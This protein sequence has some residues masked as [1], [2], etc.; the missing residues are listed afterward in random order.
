MR[1]VAPADRRDPASEYTERSELTER[2]EEAGPV[3]RRDVERCTE[4]GVYTAFGVYGVLP[5]RIPEYILQFF[6]SPPES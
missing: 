2:S 3:E 1:G 5:F 6:C 4:P